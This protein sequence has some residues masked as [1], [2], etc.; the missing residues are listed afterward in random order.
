S[1]GE[2]D[3]LSACIARHLNDLFAGGAADGGIVDQEHVLAP[4]LELDRV[5]LSSHRFLALR[6]TGHDE[7]TTDVAVLHEAFAILQAEV[8]GDADRGGTRRVR[9]GNDDINV[10]VRPGLCD[11]LRELLAHSNP[12][13]VDRDVVNHG[14]R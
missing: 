8:A 7:G 10:E 13:L 9:Y 4:E 12:A 2:V 14:V 3:L 1:G 11:V 5:E 6:L